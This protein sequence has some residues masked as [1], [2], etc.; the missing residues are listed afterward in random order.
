MGSFN[1]IQKI[2]D[3]PLAGWLMAALYFVT[4]LSCWKSGREAD[5]HDSR[6]SNERCAWQS[7][8]LLFLA[9]GVNQQLNLVTALTVLG[10]SVAYLQ[11]WYDRRQPVQIVLIAILAMSFVLVAAV[12]LIAL[13]RAPIPTLLAV[14]GA[15]LTLTFVLIR[16]ISYHQIDRFLSER[17]L[18]LRW[19]WVIEVGG[20]GLVLLA[21]QWRRVSRPKSA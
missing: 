10:R 6:R 12:L 8:A 16:A 19:N 18:S 7:I 15:M 5:L 21:S 2:G 3:P 11:G 20:I 9:L 17:I 13:R 4:S 1:W 14:T